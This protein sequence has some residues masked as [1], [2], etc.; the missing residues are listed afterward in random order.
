MM[1][2]EVKR[3]LFLA[4]SL[5]FAL[6]LFAMLLL[7]FL[8]MVNAL[9][10]YPLY[11]FL[12]SQV[13]LEEAVLHL[14]PSQYPY[15]LQKWN[16]APVPMFIVV[17]VMFSASLAAVRRFMRQVAAEGRA[18]LFLVL[19]LSALLGSVTFFN[20]YREIVLFVE[21]LLNA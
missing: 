6:Y 15:H 9:S 13:S 2:A 4:L 19:A 17:L 11:N 8:G 16:A 20:L 1:K 10:G 12:G 7:A 14:L 21:A 5:L 18:R 3:Y